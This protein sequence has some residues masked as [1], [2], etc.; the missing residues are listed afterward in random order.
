MDFDFAL[1]LV[2]AVAI[3]FVIWLV[4]LLFLRK[5]RQAEGADEPVVV[6]YANSFLP[7]LAIVL[8]I[9]SFIFEPFQIP[10]GSMIPTLKIG[11]FILVNK[12]AYGL[13]LPV[14]G[15]LIV[16]NGEPENGD[17]MVFY[18]PHNRV[19]YIKRVIGVPGDI[20][21]LRNKE[22]TINGKKADRKLLAKFNQGLLN[23]RLYEEDLAGKKHQ[24]QTIAQ[25]TRY[26]DGRWEVPEG[27]Y[28]MMGDNRDNSLDSREWGYV[29]E[30][31]IV[32]KA[33]T[34]WMHWDE[35]LSWPS[36]STAG[37]IE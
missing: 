24:M 29:P 12:F 19:Y 13:R 7:V 2:Y 11:D 20:V 26:S 35:F 27:N 18:A 37:S 34:V 1:V 32:G 31:N 28:L 5:K 30:D 15:T 21:E 4:D 23:V 22:L 10:S 25:G 3:C 9:R 8:V 33:T 6:E 14:V 36:F 16:P 17:V